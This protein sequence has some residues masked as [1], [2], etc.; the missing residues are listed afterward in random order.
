LMGEAELGGIEVGDGHPVA[1]IGVLNLSPESF[2]GG[3][4]VR[5]PAQAVRQAKRMLRQG[6]IIIDVGAMS[7]APNVKPISTSLEKKRLLPV[8]KALVKETN[9]P[10]SVDTQR[11]AIAE[12]AL[13]AGA[14]IINDVSGLKFDPKMVNVVAD[15]KCSVILM[16]ARKKPG[17]ARKIAEVCSALQDSLQICKRHSIDMR[18]VVIDPGIG[19]GKGAGWDVHILTNLRKLKGLG[20][21]I[22]VAVSR[23][24]FIGKILGLKDPADRLIGSLA[25]TAIAVRNGADVVRTH[26]VQETVQV[27]RVAEVIQHA[28]KG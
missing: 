14:S 3:S 1:I 16:A 25:A 13:E 12:V 15:L 26:D 11:A 4:V 23:K 2:Y 27:V 21:P 17:D 19:F 8:I 20:R 22:C 9:A 18:R 28:G 7:T 5:G 6:A 24:A 10:I